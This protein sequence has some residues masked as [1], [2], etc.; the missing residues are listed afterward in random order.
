MTA[1]AAIVRGT[2]TLSST[3][4]EPSPPAASGIDSVSYQWIPNAADPLVL[5][6]WTDTAASWDTS[7]LADGPYKVRVKAIDNAGNGVLSPHATTCVDNHA[8]VTADDAPSGSRASD[9]AVTLTANDGTGC[10]GVTTEYSLDGGATW[11]P[12]SSVS[13]LAPAD[14]SN[15]GSHTVRYRS[16]DAAGNQE[17]L[18]VLHG[19]DR[20]HRSSRRRPVDPGTYPPRD[21]DAHRLAFRPGCR[22]RA[23]GVQAR[24]QQ[25]PVHGDRHRHDG[26]VLRRL[27]HHRRARR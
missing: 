4:T 21:G 15:D 10:G 3:V 26:A 6:N 25:R 20:H 16:G 13:I 1:P 8:P 22:D 7:S 12:G 17:V 24:L 18:E 2:V 11:Q 27:E 14:H 23:M 5:A 9:V 19:R